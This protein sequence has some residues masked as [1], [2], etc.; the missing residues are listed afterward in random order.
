MSKVALIF[1]GTG[2]IGQAI[3]SELEK[4]GLTVY[5]TSYKEQ[6]SEVN[7]IECD[8]I[9]DQDIKNVLA[10]ILRRE[11]GIDIV[12]N[13]VTPPLKLKT[14][15][16]L[17]VKEY[18][19]DIDTILI[20]GINIAK[21]IIPIMRAHRS[22]IIINILSSL[23]LGNVS[24]RMSSYISAKYGLLGFTKCLAIELAPFNISVFGVSPAFVETS[25]IKAFPNKLIEMEQ[26]KRKSGKLVQPTEVAKVILD[27]VKN[28]QKHQT[29]ENIEIK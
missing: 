28:P 15:E 27:I 4:K 10:F 8:V 18:K 25:L 21:T 2:G 9:K 12:I 7:V 20:G 26:S 29:G 22:G 6:V 3:G 23:V 1:G 11:A 24:T 13:C 5:S 19:E 14:I 16:D 17:S